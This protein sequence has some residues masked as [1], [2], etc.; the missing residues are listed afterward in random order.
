[1]NFTQDYLEFFL[2]YDRLCAN[3][4][5]ECIAINYA[6]HI[7]LALNYAMSIISVKNYVRI[8]INMKRG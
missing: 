6:H 1:M 2:L 4:Y 5:I 7:I 3:N 8:L